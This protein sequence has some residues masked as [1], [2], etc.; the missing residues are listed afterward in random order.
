MLVV[1]IK[2]EVSHPPELWSKPHKEK[3]SGKQE[4]I[5]KPDMPRRERGRGL[6]T[7][8]QPRSHLFLACA[9]VIHAVLG[10]H[11]SGSVQ[12]GGVEGHPLHIGDVA[13]EIGQA[14]AI[15]LVWVPPVLEELLEQWGLTAL[16]K[17]GDLEGAREEQDVAG[18]GLPG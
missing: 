11:G 15:R 14:W 6:D 3:S 4:A 8:T 16:R 1:K 5:R 9:I 7:P 13:G 18:M 17:D 10:G 12:S 2:T